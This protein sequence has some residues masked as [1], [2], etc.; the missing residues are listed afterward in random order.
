MNSA[1]SGLR[2]LGGTS[3]GLQFFQLT[4]Y[5]LNPLRELLHFV[6]T[7][8]SESFEGHWPAELRQND[9]AS[10]EEL[11]QLARGHTQ[12]GPI[13]AVE[14]HVNPFVLHTPH[15]DPANRIEQFDL[16]FDAFGED[17]QL[18]G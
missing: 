12:L 10:L 6:F 1:L 9:V 16:F 14:F 18:S 7:G 11:P 8:D 17:F 2:S 13:S 4:S 15:F 5:L 3:L